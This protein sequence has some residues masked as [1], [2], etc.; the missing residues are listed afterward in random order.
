MSPMPAGSSLIAP[1]IPLFPARPRSPR[2]VDVHAV[3]I[4]AKAFTGDFYLTHRSGDRLWL[5]LG[6]V[7]GKG[8]NAALVMAMI[9]EELERSITSCAH[10][11]CDPATTMM[12]LHTFLR[13]LLPRN[14]FATVVISQLHDDGRL[15][16]ANAGH[17]P[18]LIARRDGSI[19]SVGSTGP[20]AGLLP[21]PRWHSVTLH[22]ERGESLLL[23]SDGV[24]E[25][26]TE[27]GEFADQLHDVFAAGAT[28]SVR[29]IAESIA[30]KV[31][32][33][34]H[35]DVTILVARR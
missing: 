23:Y 29:H 18:P 16:I 13:P 28:R 11:N 4:P 12:R 33:V 3:S 6:D 8:L 19:Q 22:L 20:V 25:A 10:S 15:V 14:K 7:A 24:T 5:V 27:R 35:D 17:T 30:G 21:D 31:R 2:S 34:A 26:E 9:Q 32:D 1:Q